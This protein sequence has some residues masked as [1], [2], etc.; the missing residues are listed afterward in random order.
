[1]KTIF[2]G[3]T[4]YTCRKTRKELHACSLYF[5]VIK[6]CM[7]LHFTSITKLVRDPMHFHKY[8]KLT[9]DITDVD[10]IS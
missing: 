5:E 3:M 4:K 10:V 1:M 6:T 2:E 7:L 8:A 9:F